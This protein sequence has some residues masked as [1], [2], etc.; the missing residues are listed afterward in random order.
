MAFAATLWYRK[1]S[2]SVL[3]ASESG[4]PTSDTS[5]NNKQR[6][7]SIK[8]SWW[9]RHITDASMQLSVAVGGC[10]AT[11]PRWTY[12]RDRCF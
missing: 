2:W 11:P 7:A 1:F 10:R 12:C 5:D 8:L 3:P 4:E 9:R 6:A